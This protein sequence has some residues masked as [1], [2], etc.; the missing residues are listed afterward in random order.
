MSKKRMKKPIRKIASFL[1]RQITRIQYGATRF[2]FIFAMSN[3]VS[4]LLL[5]LTNIGL[6]LKPIWLVVIYVSMFL[7]GLIFI[8]SIE[9]LGGW[10]IEKRQL[11]NMSNAVL[12]K[13]QMEYNSLKIAD[14]MSL[15]KEERDARKEQ[16]EKRLFGDK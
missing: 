1:I 12:W 2:N 16:I 3:F 9:K 8:I 4:L 14:A 5:V 6:T 10:Q 11:F 15:S 7:G 13:D